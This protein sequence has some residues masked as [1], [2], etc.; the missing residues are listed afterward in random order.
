MVL[1]LRMSVHV[2]CIVQVHDP[3]CIGLSAAEGRGVSRLLS[4]VRASWKA[5]N[6]RVYTA[7]L[8][9][10]LSQ[11]CVLSYTQANMPMVLDRRAKSTMALRLASSSTGCGT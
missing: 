11:V 9:K 10:W 8:N 2:S 1:L 4:A 5:W 3:P 7:Q 6:H